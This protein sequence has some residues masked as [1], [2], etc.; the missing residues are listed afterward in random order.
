MQSYFSGKEADALLPNQNFKYLESSRRVKMKLSAQAQTSINKVIEKFKTGDLSPISKVVRINLDKS[1]P[2]N[3]WS[4]SNK[5]LAFMQSKEL[6]CRG[7][8]QWQKVD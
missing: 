3:N 1:A 2:A 8:R 7:F 4:L 6:D 5:V